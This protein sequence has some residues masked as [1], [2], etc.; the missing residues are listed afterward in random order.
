MKKDVFLKIFFIVLLAIFSACSDSEDEKEVVILEVKP[1][2]LDFPAI[3]ATKTVMVTC[4]NVEWTFAS[5]AE[6]CKVEKTGNELNITVEPYNELTLRQAR[7]TVKT[8][9]AADQVINVRQAAAAEATLVIIPDTLEI[10]AAKEPVTQTLFVETNQALVTIAEKPAEWCVVEVLDEAESITVTPQENTEVEGRSTSFTVR[11]GEEPN[12]KEQVVTVKQ[13]VARL[14][15]IEKVEL[16]EIGYRVIVP[17]DAKPTEYTAAVG[18]DWCKVMVTERGLEICA[19]PFVEE[20]ER[21]TTV[22][23]S[24]KDTVMASIAVTQIGGDLKLHDEFYYNGKLVGVVGRIQTP[25]DWMGNTDYR[26]IWVIAL[27][28]K[29][30]LKWSID[31]TVKLGNTVNS[32]SDIVWR[33]IKGYSGWNTKFPCYAYCNEM[34][35]K[36]GMANWT[37]GFPD[38][39]YYIY[40][41]DKASDTRGKDLNARME[42]LGGTPLNGFYW[43]DLESDYQKES[44][45][46]TIQGYYLFN[47]GQYL[48]KWFGKDE[49]EPHSRCIWRCNYDLGYHTDKDN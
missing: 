21:K 18:A 35:E 13:D 8:N 1:A 33:K 4:S 42:A 47:G 43:S 46:P 32:T 28:E 23:V 30:D 3:G 34:S 6:W 19:K 24:M 25:F 10:F 22:K 20:N 2:T 17:V 16:N 37:L 29:D 36:T 31:P 48:A 38:E 26:V 12:I 45:N 15:S 5:D 41:D 14:I 11:V 9:N 44:K 7:I 40:R 49:V 27:E 39:L